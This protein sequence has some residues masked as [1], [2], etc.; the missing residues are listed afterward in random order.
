MDYAVN[1][2]NQYRNHIQTHII[3]ENDLN[4]YLNLVTTSSY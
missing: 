2:P 1:P 3:L 4:D